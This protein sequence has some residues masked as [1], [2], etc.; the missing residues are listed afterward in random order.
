MNGKGMDRHLF[1]LRKIASEH[2]RKMPA[3]FETDAYKKMM[4][5]TL[6]TSQVNKI[7]NNLYK[8]FHF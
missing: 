2:G 7:K 1:G 6:S 8:D 5:F 4:A 3:I